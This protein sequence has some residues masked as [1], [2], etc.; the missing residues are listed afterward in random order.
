[1]RYFAKDLFIIVLYILH[2]SYPHH[3]KVLF[4]FYKSAMYDVGAR[5]EHRF[6]KKSE[7][8]TDD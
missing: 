4:D 6:P 5:R 1:M 7:V 3:P 8:N 2:K